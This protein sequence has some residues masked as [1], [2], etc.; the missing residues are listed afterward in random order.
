M[1]QLIDLK[2]T[3]EDF[4][5]HVLSGLRRSEKKI[6]PKFLY[7]SRGSELFDEICALAEYYPTRTERGILGSS[8]WEIT[9]LVG[10]GALLVEPG[11]GNGDKARAL[12]NALENPAGFVGVEISK[13]H[14]ESALDGLSAS[15]PGLPVSG[16]CAD[17][18]L[19]H[20]LPEIEIERRSTLVFLP[21]STI[22][23]FESRTRGELLSGFRGVAGDDGWLLIGVDLRKDPSVI[24]AAY[25]DEAGVT[26]EFNKNLLRRM[27]RELGA[28]FDLAAFEHIAVYDERSSRIEMRLV[29]AEDQTVEVAGQPVRF[30]GGEPIVTE[31]SHKFDVEAFVDECSAHGWARAGV[32]RDDARYFAVVLLRAVGL[33]RRS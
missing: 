25:N 2:P 28:G 27:N 23:N 13:S 14:L 3:T 29:S 15:F 31:Y 24:R 6:S 9:A 4:R 10:P 22:G 33:N 16:V 21:G 17:F 18:T 26:A 8:M 20:E 1:V 11:L 7:D 32:W 19:L 5:S 12:L 30:D